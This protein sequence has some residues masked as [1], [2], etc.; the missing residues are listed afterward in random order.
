MSDNGLML[1]YSQCSTMIWLWEKENRNIT[2][3]SVISSI[4]AVYLIQIHT[5]FLVIHA[6]KQKAGFWPTDLAVS[7]EIIGVCNNWS[8]NPET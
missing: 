6:T 7:L 3:L 5:V 1:I 2:Y 4:H 8:L